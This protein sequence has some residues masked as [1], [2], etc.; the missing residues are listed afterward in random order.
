[1]GEKKEVSMKSVINKNDA[2]SYLE[3]MA[4]A[5]REGKVVVSNNSNSI[6]LNP[7]DSVEI[8]LEAEAKK[9]KESLSIE[10]SWRKEEVQDLSEVKLTIGSEEPKN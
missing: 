6:T 4:K 1:M 10:L 9:G 2:A 7:E 8:E 5:L 3:E